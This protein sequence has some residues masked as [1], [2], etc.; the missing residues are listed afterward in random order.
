MNTTTATYKV[1]KL[2]NGEELICEMGDGEI[3]D[4]YEI[5]HPL[6][7]QVESKLTKQGFVDSLNLSRWIGPYTEQSLFSIKMSHVLTIA[8]ASEGLSRYYEHVRKEIKRVDK[9][10][11]RKSLDDIKNEDVYK[12]LLEDLETEDTIH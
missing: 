12:D 4:S 1:L 2:L 6:K 5:S 9:H 3:E 10:E 7:M 8:D 11:Y